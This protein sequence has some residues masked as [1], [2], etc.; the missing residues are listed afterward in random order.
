MT[1]L[2][3]LITKQ[4][5]IQVLLSFVMIHYEANTYVMLYTMCSVLV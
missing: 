4:K 1:I 3:I 5:T 2:I